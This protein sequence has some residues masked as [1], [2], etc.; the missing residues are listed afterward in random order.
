MTDTRDNLGRLVPA[1]PLPPQP[2][3]GQ[4]ADQRALQEFSALEYAAVA[5]TAP[6]SLTVTR[7]REHIATLDGLG[8]PRAVPTDTATAVTDTPRSSPFS[9]G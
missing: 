1:Q 9:L 8:S 4:V 7:L 3:D 5:G 2:G 6:D